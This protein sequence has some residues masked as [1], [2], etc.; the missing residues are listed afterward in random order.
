MDD[1]SHILLVKQRL[2]IEQMLHEASEAILSVYRSGNNNTRLK[3]DNSPVTEADLRS[4]KIILDALQTITPDIP[5][6]SEESAAGSW[7]W[8]QNHNLLWILDPLDGTREFL[9]RNDQ[10]CICLALVNHGLPVAG[11]IMIPV[12]NELWSAYKG[13]G[14]SVVKDGISK[15]VI[16]APS[17]S[18]LRVLM[19]RSHMVESEK[20]WLGRISSLM[21]V[22]MKQAG[23]AIKFCHVADGRAD[24]YTKLGPINDWD[25]AAGNLLVTEAGGTMMS[26]DGSDGVRYNRESTNQNGF[27]AITSSLARKKMDRSV[28]YVS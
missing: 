23:S 9:A 19:S 21:P 25:I 10:F 17:G 26:T 4:E 28:F 27:I 3:K 2:R 6:L 5:V 22:E 24:I 16:P 8:R 12:D 15:R 18:G 14:V 13:E 1:T 20:E 7:S 11:F